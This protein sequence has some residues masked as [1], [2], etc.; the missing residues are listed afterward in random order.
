MAF[1]AIPK[2]VAVLLMGCYRSLGRGYSVLLV[3]PGLC[4]DQAT[5]RTDGPATSSSRCL[6][7]PHA[8]DSG[9]GLRAQVALVLDTQLLLMLV[10]QVQLLGHNQQRWPPLHHKLFHLGQGMVPISV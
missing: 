2:D 8:V 3:L 5:T 4:P 7:G 6:G 9:P 1:E 10:V